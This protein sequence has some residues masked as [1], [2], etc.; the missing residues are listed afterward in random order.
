MKGEGTPGVIATCDVC[1]HRCRL[2]PGALGACR[3]R[4]NVNGSVACEAYGRLTSIAI[5]PV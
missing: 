1:P 3:A 5:D 4:R 2:E